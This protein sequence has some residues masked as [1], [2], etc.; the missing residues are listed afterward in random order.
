MLSKTMKTIAATVAIYTAGALAPA[1]AAEA[2]YSPVVPVSSSS[3][4]NAVL[5]HVFARGGATRRVD[6]FRR[7]GTLSVACDALFRSRH[8]RSC[9]RR[10]WWRDGR[11][12]AGAVRCGLAVT[13]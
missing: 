13:R 5:A 3:A 2:T 12:T 6:C 8:G 4:T 11:L 10:Y 7:T 9:T 1:P